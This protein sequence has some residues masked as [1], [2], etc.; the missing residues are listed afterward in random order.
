MRKGGENMN[1]YFIKVSSLICA[2]L[3]LT[4][5][6]SRHSIERESNNNLSQKTYSNIHVGWLDLGEGNWTTFGY[7]SKEMWN[8][9]IDRINKDCLQ[10]YLKEQLQGKALSFSQF[11]DDPPPNGSDLYVWFSNTEIE[12]NWPGGPFDYIYTTV[13]FTDVQSNKEA[14]QAAIKASSMS[15]NPGANYTV[16]GRLGSTAYNIGLMISDKLR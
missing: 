10:P 4:S 5:C 12:G 16:E 14:Y 15:L 3:L 7:D 13:H 11:K 8:E 1:K 2:F 6:V 9:A